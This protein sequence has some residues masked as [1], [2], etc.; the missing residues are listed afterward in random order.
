[1]LFWT[2]P[3]RHHTKQQLYG[4]FIPILQTIQVRRSKHAGTDGKT[5]KL[6][7]NFLLWTPTHGCANVGRPPAKKYKLCADTWRSLKDLPG[8]IGTDGESLFG[9]ILWHM[10]PYR[11]F[12]AK[13]WLYV[14]TYICVFVCV[15][16]CVCVC[17]CGLL[18]I[19]CRQY[20]NQ[21]ELIC[22][23]S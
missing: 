14:H 16:V 21:P 10:N 5:K 12:I 19:A 11:L 23:H 22:L 20:L 6:I 8:S 4:R 15:H 7:S 17:M 2:N 18:K 1:M 9:W 3:G 13:S